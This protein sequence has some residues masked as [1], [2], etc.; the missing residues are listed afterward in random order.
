MP[1]PCGSLAK[2]PTNFS[3]PN[4]PDAYAHELESLGLSRVTTRSS[5][6]SP[7]SA[8]TDA[9]SLRHSQANLPAVFMEA[10]QAV[11]RPELPNHQTRT[12]SF[13]DG[14]EESAPRSQA[15]GTRQALL[16]MVTLRRTTNCGS[17]R[18]CSFKN[19]MCPQRFEKPKISDELKASDCGQV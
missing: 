18:T 3:I 14:C 11:G 19:T 16:I 7:S 9:L 1:K 10:C 8:R 12:L 13:W 6:I 2:L 15:L 17:R 4:S 5:R